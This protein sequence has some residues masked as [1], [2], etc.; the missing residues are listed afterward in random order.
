[1]FLV[2]V[3]ACLFLGA[4]FALLIRPELAKPGPTIMNETTAKIVSAL[5]V[6]ETQI[7]PQQ[8]YNRA[9]T[10]HGAIMIFLFVIPAVP[11]S[12]GNFILP[13]QLGAKDVAFPRLNLFSYH[14]FFFGTLFFVLTLLLGWHRHGLDVLRPVQRADWHRRHDGGDGCVSCWG[15]VRSSPA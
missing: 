2:S 11:S 10:L 4:T 5:S 1:M 7:T 9:F 12:L 13:L 15:L 6:T 3:V 14:L 8:M